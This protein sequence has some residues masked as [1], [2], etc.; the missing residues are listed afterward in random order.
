MELY[1]VY[2][3]W[4]LINGD[5]KELVQVQLAATLHHLIS[6]ASQNVATQNVCS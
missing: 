4:T 2:T 5:H 1:L 3:R 6:T